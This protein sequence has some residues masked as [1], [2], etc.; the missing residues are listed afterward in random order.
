[1]Y[2]PSM[3]WK[4]TLERRD[5]QSQIGYIASKP[6]LGAR[7]VGDLCHRTVDTDHRR[8]ACEPRAVRCN[9]SIKTDP[10]QE[11][12]RQ[13]GGNAC[14]TRVQVELG[15]RQ[16]CEIVYINAMLNWVGYSDAGIVMSRVSDVTSK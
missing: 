1:M 6:T 5:K 8:D 2:L 4:N 13:L 14:R 11:I 9:V 10:R 16:P 7:G 3:L 15:P 12:R